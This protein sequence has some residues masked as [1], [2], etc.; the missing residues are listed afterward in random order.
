M[1]TTA[2]AQNIGKSLIVIIIACGALGLSACGATK[3]MAP[4]MAPMAIEQMAPT[5]AP[6]PL[7]DNHFK[8]DRT[9]NITE[10]QLKEILD[11]P[12]FLED[13]SRVGIVPVA[14]AYEVD[15][16]LPLA[17]GPRHLS[18][19][20]EDTGM[21]DVTTEVSTDWPKTRSIAG[22]RELAARYRVRYLLL[23]RHRFVDREYTN[24]WGWSYPTVIGA[25]AAPA[26]TLEAAGV[27][28][29]SLFDVRTGTILFTVF[30][31][32]E[33]ESDENLWHLDSKRRL[34]KEALLVK[35]TEA[36]ARQMVHKVQRLDIARQE[37]EKE[38]QPPAAPKSTPPAGPTPAAVTPASVAPSVM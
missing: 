5:Q 13:T 22:L 15:A 26:K 36:L 25:L 18:E 20:L 31:R 2:L 23:Y 27:M 10:D 14:T 34:L 1:T 29:A 17:D 8:T 19:A 30:Q 12:V 28:E 6:A 33:G 3:S 37:W 21:F 24:S 7:A 16:D 32:V 9:G 38:H 35:G 4:K 11:A